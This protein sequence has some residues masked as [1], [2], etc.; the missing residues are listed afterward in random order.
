MNLGLELLAS[1]AVKLRLGTYFETWIATPAAAVRRSLGRD[2]F[3]LA[4]TVAAGHR[5]AATGRTHISQVDLEAAEM[6]PNQ[7]RPAVLVPV[8]VEA[9][10]PVI[11][12]IRTNLFL[13]LPALMEVAQARVIT[14][15]RTWLLPFD[16]PD[17]AVTE[18]TAGRYLV[19][20]TRLLRES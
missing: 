8:D 20:L 19:D 1:R 13:S 15:E 7:V 9:G 12:A 2:E 6:G 18:V 3:H 4:L 16:H 14:G 11:W 5:L 10:D 17:L